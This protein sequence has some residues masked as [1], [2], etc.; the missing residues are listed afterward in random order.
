MGSLPT[1]S[2][3]DVVKVFAKGGGGSSDIVEAT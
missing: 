1:L 3:A 2:G